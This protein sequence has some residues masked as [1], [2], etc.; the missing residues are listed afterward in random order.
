VADDGE[1]SHLPT[2]ALPRR[3]IRSHE[4]S[5]VDIRVHM[6]HIDLT[7]ELRD[8]ARDKVTHAV[9]VFDGA[10]DSVALEFSERQNPRRADE[11]F[12]ME[13]T[14]LVTGRVVRVEAAAPE[15]RTAIDQATD[16]FERRLRDLK[17]RLITTHRRG[18]K[19]LNDPEWRD[20][21]E[22]EDRVLAIDRVKRFEVKPM[23]TEEAALQMELLG[24]SF[25]LFLNADT[26][27]YSV[28]YRRSEGSLGLIEAV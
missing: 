13:I 16:R 2:A 15:P 8:L 24:H 28:L 19:R 20:E 27:R 21:D 14:T 6:K 23:T 9:R 1:V 22:R 5:A 17:E 7:D 3:A 12:R 25:Y 11:R 10:V 4:R 26:D 18:E